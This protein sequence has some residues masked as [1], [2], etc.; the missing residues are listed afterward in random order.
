MF[1][2]E[3]RKMRMNRNRK[4]CGLYFTVLWL[5]AIYYYCR[6]EGKWSARVKTRFSGERACTFLYAVF[7]ILHDQP[8]TQKPPDL[9]NTHDQFL[10]KPLA[11]ISVKHGLAV[12]RRSFDS[13]TPLFFAG[14][15]ISEPHR[16]VDSIPVPS[17]DVG[18]LS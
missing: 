3:L 8:P 2:L 6:W 7:A 1:A 9:M 15:S 12:C 10:S 14:I 17:A 4:D 16:D 5:C 11:L 13:R 18:D